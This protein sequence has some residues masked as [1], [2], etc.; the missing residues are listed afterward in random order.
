MTQLTV[1]LHEKQS[2]IEELSTQVQTLQSEIEDL[3]AYQARLQEDYEELQN[4]AEARQQ[5]I[6]ILSSQMQEALRPEADAIS[7]ELEVGEL[8]EVRCSFCLLGS[9][10]SMWLRLSSWRSSFRRSRI[11]SRRKKKICTLCKKSASIW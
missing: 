3:H 7:E 6:K 5:E 2:L 9:R 4:M 8:L 1:V 11:S 10:R